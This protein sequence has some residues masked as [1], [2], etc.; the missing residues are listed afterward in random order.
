MGA[1]FGSL[2]A[3]ARD[4]RAPF[5]DE[6]MARLAAMGT[7]C[8]E[9]A[10]VLGNRSAL[11]N[12]LANQ[13]DLGQFRFT[14]TS[15][16]SYACASPLCLHSWRHVSALLSCVEQLLDGDPVLSGLEEG[17]GGLSEAL[18][19][20][21]EAGNPALAI[22]LQRKG[23]TLSAEDKLSYLGRVREGVPYPLAEALA[24]SYANK[25]P[26]MVGA[27][28]ENH[29]LDNPM[30]LASVKLPNVLG[31]DANL[32]SAVSWRPYMTSS[33]FP[34]RLSLL[35]ALA[36]HGPASLFSEYLA[37]GGSVDAC[38]AD[39]F[40]VYR[41]A[42]RAGN[43]EV[44]ELLLGH[45]ATNDATLLDWVVG[46]CRNNDDVEV[47][48]LLR[49]GDLKAADFTLANIAPLFQAA[50]SG[51]A[52]RVELFVRAGW[53]VNARDSAM[54][55]ALHGAAWHGHVEIV[56]LLME[57]GANQRI[58][59]GVYAETPLQW[60]LDGARHAGSAGVRHHQTIELLTA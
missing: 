33:V 10:C 11:S 34:R 52:D 12:I 9:A 24:R 29:D 48:R 50:C 26:P 25:F 35:H 4:P 20:A 30:T 32:W 3:S 19:L 5:S 54:A 15:C 14:A 2:L 6:D 41:S 17:P 18:L 49:C 21:L 39:G 46:R 58:T 40:S 27:A 22:L 55:T 7:P 36:E 28:I 47:E 59:D 45:G 13:A 31:G 37:L 8:V 23:A 38:D 57:R 53:P 56:R 42:V 44:G 16:L 60:A 51:S 1:D 43:F